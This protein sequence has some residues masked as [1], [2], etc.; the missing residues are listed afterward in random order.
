MRPFKRP[1]FTMVELLTVMAVIGILL[2]ILVPTVSQVRVY[3]RTYKCQRNLHEIGIAFPNCKANQRWSTDPNSFKALYWTGALRP[4]L[5]KD[6]SVFFC[7]E[8]TIADGNTVTSA[9][10][11]MGSLMVIAYGPN[12][13]TGVWE[14]DYYILPGE[15]P[16]GISNRTIHWQ[17][18]SRTATAWKLALEDSWQDNPATSNYK[19][20]VLDF[21]MDGPIATK[22]TYVSQGTGAFQYSLAYADGIVILGAM[23]YGHGDYGKSATINTNLGTYGMTSLAGQIMPSKRVILVLDYGK[24][25]ADC[26]GPN[27]MDDWGKWSAPR[28]MGRCNVLFAD[29]GAG[30]FTL[31][32]IDPTL[33]SNQQ[34][35][36]LWLP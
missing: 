30:S 5:E 16:P 3:Y 14:T 21:T 24:T 13:W 23:G 25:V 15:L 19:D 4:Y 17:T 10:G 9:A 26:A 32:E 18:I 1:A 28:H 11:E 31:D 33:T 36:Q 2:A 29:G 7:P 34:I 27:H 8:T 12:R 20:L 6:D 22:V 35:Q